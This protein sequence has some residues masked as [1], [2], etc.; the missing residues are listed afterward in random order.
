[1]LVR[2]SFGRCSSA[3]CTWIARATCPRSR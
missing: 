1:V 2:V 3:W